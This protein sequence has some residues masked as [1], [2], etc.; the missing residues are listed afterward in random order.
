MDGYSRTPKKVYPIT[1]K[2]IMITF[3]TMAKT[4][5]RKLTDGK[6]IFKLLNYRVGEL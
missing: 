2:S 3:I 5:R 6:P 1:P 4:G